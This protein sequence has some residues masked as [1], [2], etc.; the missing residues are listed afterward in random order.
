M[1]SFFLGHNDR[2]GAIV[3]HPQSTLSLS[4]SSPVNMASCAADGSVVLWN[5]KK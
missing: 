1:I 5:L 4:P 3:F 2:V